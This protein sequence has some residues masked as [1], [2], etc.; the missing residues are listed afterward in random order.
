MLKKKKKLI[1]GTPI[2]DIPSQAVPDIVIFLWQP[3]LWQSKQSCWLLHF[4]SS[5]LQMC[6]IQLPANALEYPPYWHQTEKVHR[7]ADNQ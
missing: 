5:S 4:C 2:R 1:P 7:K 3:V 6:L